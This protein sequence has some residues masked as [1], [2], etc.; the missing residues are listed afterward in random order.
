MTINLDSQEPVIRETRLGAVTGYQ[1]TVGDLAC[2]AGGCRL[3]NRERGFT[4][5]TSC[6]SGCAQALLSQIRDAAVVNHAPL[7]CAGDTV[8]QNVTNHWGEYIRRWPYSNLPVLNTNM[9]EKETVFGGG[10]KLRGA[11]R[12]AHRRFQAKAIFVTTSCASAI[13]GDDIAGVAD[14]LKE[15][16]AIP[17]IPVSC[18]GFRSKVWA[19]GFDAAFHALFQGIIQP[20]RRKRPERVNI[21]NFWG[22][23]KDRITALLGR[24]G[25]EPQFIIPFASVDELAHISEAAATLTVCGTLGTYLAAGL[26]QRYGVPQVKSLPPHGIAGMDS[27]L[28]ELGKVVGKQAEVE[29]LIAEEK[30]RI[31]PELAQIRSRLQGKRAVLGMGPGFGHGFLGV[32]DELGLD[33]VRA[34]SWHFDARHDYG[35]CPKA[36]Q[37]LAERQDGLP[38]SVGDQQNFEIINLLRQIKPDI[39]FSRHVGTAVW[40]AKL[41]ITTVAV[42]DEYSAFGYQGLI[43]FGHR[44]ID[45]QLN[46]SFAQRLSSKVKLPY[47]EWWLSQDAFALLKAAEEVG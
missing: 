43:D 40:A 16:L 35:Q 27:W 22:R 30:A 44:V 31:A 21:I 11:I 34:V 6:S 37:Q 28:R 45:A 9:S 25:L 24:L 3:K 15:E 12:E 29:A 46:R 20:P 4:Q 42:T 32:L 2:Q 38:F 19:S 18:E 7:G 13:I 17:I 33:V 5:T 47:T 10:E 36:T 41:G 8:A 14:S 39:Y 1:G 26:E 23:A